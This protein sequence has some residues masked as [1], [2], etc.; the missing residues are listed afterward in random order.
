MLRAAKLLI[1]VCGFATLVWGC[2]Y[3]A[4]YNPAYVEKES[5]F[6]ETEKIDG[7]IL[8]YTEK[9]DDQVQYSGHPTSFTGSASTLTIPL[10]TITREIAETVFGGLFRSGAQHANSLDDANA[11]T[12]V[13]SPKV[14]QFSYEYDALKNL[15][16]AITPTVSVTLSVSILDA[17]GAVRWTQSYESDKFETPAYVASGSPGERIGEATH[18]AIY[19]LM[20]RAAKDVREQ[21]GKP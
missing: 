21:V 11:Y 20:V 9:A 3:Q 2:A 19:A 1:G 17:S 15:G 16:F 10:G 13:L 6:V 18:K 5:S 4:G 8:I 14:T 7:R 12:M